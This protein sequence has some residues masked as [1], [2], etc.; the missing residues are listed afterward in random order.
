MIHADWVKIL[1]AFL[2]LVRPEKRFVFKGES[3]EGHFDGDIIVSPSSDEK[4][5]PALVIRS[6]LSGIQLKDISGIQ[7]RSDSEISGILGGN[8]TYEGKDSEGAVNAKLTLTDCE[9][10]LAEPIFSLETLGFGTIDADLE[11]KQKT[12]QVR[13]CVM[14]GH[15]VG[16]NFSGR[17]NLKEPF[18]K[19]MLNL[20]GAIKPHPS[21]IA[22]LGE[23]AAL[24]LKQ[25]SGADGFPFSIRGTFESP[26]FS[27]K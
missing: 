21:F 24:L 6:E 7:D 17:I 26:E 9:I 19:S 16:G 15:Q 3:H 13:Q 25:G 12:I 20:A 10:G 2:T 11:I 4:N 5:T 23:G 22:N 1:P 27:L 18:E 8:I 14:T